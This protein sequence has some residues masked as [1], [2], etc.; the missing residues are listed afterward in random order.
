MRPATTPLHLTAALSDDSTAL[1]AERPLLHDLVSAL[2]SPLNIIVPQRIR[3]NL[4]GF[5]RVLADRHITGQV[6]YAHKA[7]RSSALVRELAATNAR[8]DVASLA[9]LQHVLGCGF[10]PDRI[11]AT[12][13]KT[14]EML[15]L[16]ATVGITINVDGV[17]ELETLARTVSA[18][19]LPSVRVLVR[20]GEFPTLGTTVL[21]KRSRFGCTPADIDPI[22]AILDKYRGELELHGVAFH[23]DTVGAAEKTRAIEGSLGVLGEFARRG[24]SPTVID[25]GGGFGVNYLAHAQEWENFTTALGAALLGRR[26]HITWQGAGYGLRND[27]GRLRGTLGL[28]PA[29]RPV[30]GPSYLADLLDSPA[31]ATRRPLGTMIL[32]SMY[33]L[34]VEPGRAL[35]DQCGFALARV[36]E[37]RASAAG[38]TL[39]RLD[40]N[41]RDVSLEEHGVQL[42]PVVVAAPGERS[43][44]PGGEY[45]PGPGSGYLI[46]NLCLESD[47]ISRRRID[48]RVMPTPGDLLAFPNTAGYFMDFSADHAL[49]QPIAA[50]VAMY[51]RS[52]GWAWTL[53][54]QYW[55]TVSRPAGDIDSRYDDHEER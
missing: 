38:E 3:E 33:D 42:D 16:G 11:M 52:D 39:I 2:G 29:Y 14:P 49:A 1:L 35:L 37:V 47:L 25:I 9:E 21:S 32:E 12:G 26:D 50:K 22:V 27:G 53:D 51:R 4:G 30:A 45:S 43:G 13:P 19:D 24:F 6:Y 40:M 10:R 18:A 23:L 28:Y 55:P 5:Q 20:F 31:A 17:D 7:N 34:Y 36:L 44:A 15:W 41:A 8:I 54:E 46:G 48:F